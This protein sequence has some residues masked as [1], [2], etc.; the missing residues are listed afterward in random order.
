M[1]DTPLKILLLGHGKLGHALLEGLL[2]TPA[3]QIVGVFQWSNRKPLQPDVD[4]DER[5]F[6]QRVKQL[7]LPSISCPGANSFEF[8]AEVERL[9]PDVILIG[10]WGEIL[11]KH[12]LSLPGCQVINCHPS[13]LPAHRG[14]IPYCSVIRAQEITTGVTFH[15]VDTG[16]DTG[17][18]LLQEPVPLSAEDTG[19]DVRDRCALKA[20][21][22]TPKLVALLASGQPLEPIPQNE[23][24][25]S[26]H[27]PLKME[28]GMVFWE[29]EP[30]T[31]HNQVRALQPWLDCYTFLEGQVFFVFAKSTLYYFKEGEGPQPYPPTPGTIVSYEKGVLWVSTCYTD[32]L[33]GL[34]QFKLYVLWFFLPRWLSQIIGRVLFQKGLTLQT[35]QRQPSAPSQGA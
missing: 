18:I 23:A 4:P 33:I 5:R 24:A 1:A 14:A 13:L 16:I 15:V 3:C 6:T 12:A 27:K 25:K 19:G 29:D 2:A 20:R 7:K 22:M 17:P 26:Y 11:K 21:E 31:I 30:E 34:S 10:S 8:V 32:T 35:Y 28:D 9:R